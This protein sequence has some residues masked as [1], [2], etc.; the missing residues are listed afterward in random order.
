MA[1]YECGDFDKA[2]SEY[3]E[4]IR[5]DPDSAR[6]FALR[7]DVY[8]DQKEYDEAIADYTRAI[9]LG[10]KN[11]EAFNSRGAAYSN[12]KEYGK[13]LADYAEAIR[14]DP[15]SARPYNNTAWILATCPNDAVRDGGKALELATKACE[16]SR[17]KVA[18]TLDTLAAAHAESGNP[19]EAVGWQKKAMELTY[20]NKEEAENAKRRLKL[21][22]EGKPYREE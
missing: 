3:T 16:L 18:H 13:A 21:Y 14:I 17:W 19:E 7:A 11:A 20:D 9:N 8:Y 2:I 4:A 6:A 1:S 5:L 10:A 12:H 15:D 22:E